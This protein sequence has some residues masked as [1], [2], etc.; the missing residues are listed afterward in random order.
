MNC[1]IIILFFCLKYN[2][3]RD[4]SYKYILELIL[5]KTINEL[6]SLTYLN[7]VTS[8]ITLKLVIYRKEYLFRV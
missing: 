3:N 7:A 4:R 1:F 8:K 5:I 6:I 2:K